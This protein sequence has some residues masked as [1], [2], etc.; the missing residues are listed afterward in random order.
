MFTRICTAAEINDG[1]LYRFD[2]NDKPLLVTKF[3]GNYFVTDSICTHEEADLSLGMFSG[4]P[5]SWPPRR[6]QFGS[7]TGS[8]KKG[9]DA[10]AAD[11]LPPLRIYPSK[12]ENAEVWAE[13]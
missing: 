1:E 10:A 12:V 9:R 6:A 7:A 4:C 3:S 5:L 2:V 11:S 8:I 13:L